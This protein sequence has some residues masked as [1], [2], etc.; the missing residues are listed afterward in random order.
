[1]FVRA[2]TRKPA[3]HIEGSTIDYLTAQTTGGVNEVYPAEAVQPAPHPFGARDGGGFSEPAYVFELRDIDFWGCYGGSIVTADNHLRADLSPEVWGI[4]NHPI[5]SSLHLPKARPLSGRTAIV[6]TPE[7]PAN[8]YHWIVDLLPRVALIREAAGNFENFERILIN[9]SRAHYEQSSLAA[10]GVPANELIYVDARHRFRIASST[11]PSMDHSSKI[12]APWKLRAL[13][14][15]RDGLIDIDS[16]TPSRIYIS[17]KNA[18][19]R[20]VLNE[21]NL[22]PALREAGFTM[23]ELE[24]L[25]WS[26]QVRLFSNAAVVLAPHGAALANIAFCRPNTVVAEIGTRAG[27]RDFYLRLAASGSLRY[28]FIEARPRTKP[29]PASRRAFEDEDMVLDEQTLKN[30]LRNL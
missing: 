16:G 10:F 13:R 4:E 7:A 27:Y 23:I 1:M 6:V 26:E 30:F 28:D 15:M 12:V 20:R 11:I 22:A 14:Q 18:V 21:T 29:R 19:V 3:P 24:P 25:L 8:Y 17:R 5:F 2:I 9:G